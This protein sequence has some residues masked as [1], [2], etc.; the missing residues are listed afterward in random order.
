MSADDT[1][2]EEIIELA[3]NRTGKSAVTPETRLYADLGMTGDDAHEFLLA[4]A[5]KYDVDMERLIWLRFFDDEPSTNDLMAPAI[6]LAASVLSPSFAIR[7]QAARDAEREIT[8][9]H[10]ADVARAKVW[11]DPGDAYRRTRG[12]SPLV[13]IFSAASLSLLAFFVLLGIAVG[14]AF[15]AGQLGDKNY[16]AL[17]GVLAV[18]VLPFFFAFSSWQSI[19]RKLA[20]A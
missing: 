18:S 1:L 5:T 14:Y 20:S 11:S 19:Q 9:A 4:F 12:H 3:K 8:I 2:L 7:W 6:T 10:L 16:I 17:L 13:L 15:L